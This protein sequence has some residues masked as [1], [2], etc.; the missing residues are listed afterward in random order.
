VNIDCFYLMVTN[1]T[2]HSNSSNFS[3]KKKVILLVLPPHMTHLLQP[4]DVAIFQPPSKY[5]RNEVENHSR[6]KHY[7]LKMED[8]IRYYQTAHKKALQETNILSAWRTTGMLP[9]NPQKVIEKLLNRPTTPS[10]S[11]QIQLILNGNSCQF[12]R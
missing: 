4:L 11:T 8:F 3:A 5:Y 1:H 9:F 6:E 2:V 10:E 7:W 12:A